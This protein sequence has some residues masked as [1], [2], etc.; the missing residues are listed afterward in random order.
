MIGVYRNLDRP[1]GWPIMRHSHQ[2]P[3]FEAGPE[4][5]Q[6]NVRLLDRAVAS[7]APLDASPDWLLRSR[8]LCTP[9]ER[10][11]LARSLLIVLQTAQHALADPLTR[12]DAPA[13][14]DCS[15]RL[16]A[17]VALLE[18][19][20]RCHAQGLALAWLLIEEPQS[21]LF[22]ANPHQTLEHALDEI[23]AAL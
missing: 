22:H 11:E 5:E 7:G 21:P 12:L 14:L 1:W 13:I 17:L 4:H 9:S 20:C 15:D 3:A 8:E 10:H 18:T 19:D 2:L 6:P 23:T 16:L